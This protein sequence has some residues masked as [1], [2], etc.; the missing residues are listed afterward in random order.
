MTPTEEDVLCTTLDDCT[1]SPNSS[2]AAVFELIDCS[3]LP[4]KEDEWKHSSNA[5]ERPVGDG[6]H[7]QR[8]WE[9]WRNLGEPK[10]I[11]APMVDQSELPF[12]MLCRKYGATAAYTPMLHSRLFAEDPKYRRIEFT[13]CKED[14]PLF[15][16]FC[17]N[18]PERLLAAAQV[19][20]PFC[21][22]VDINLG[23]PQR[24]AK[25]G[26]SLL[27]VH[28]RTRDQKDGSNRAD[29]A[30]IKAVKKA[31]KIPV[32]ANGNIRHLQDVYD[33][34]R[35]TGA[36]GIL[37]A[38]SILGNPALFAG[39]QLITEQSDNVI[40][41]S[42]VLEK[43]EKLK[44]SE[45]GFEKALDQ[46]T[47]LLEYFD[48]CETYPVPWRMIRAHV[49]RMLG[50]WFRIHPDIREE[51]NKQSK[52]TFEWLRDMVD[53]LVK[54]DIKLV[55]RQAIPDELVHKSLPKESL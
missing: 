30:T 2:D 7:V 49:H 52:L 29:W 46:A 50:D 37:S 32:L 34:L 5:I 53:R 36:D 17:A 26:C 28:G 3:V 13:T 23:C 44:H 45:H 43:Y 1:L 54:R 19:V 55:L 41:Q 25:R 16:Q 51:L 20:Q 22:Y 35:E 47:L 42:G 27:A 48:L 21:D 14:R 10:F 33:C 8:A 39:Y 31:L 15:V 11:V 24:I 40:S 38:E 12:R 18:D 9:Y 4:S 6:G